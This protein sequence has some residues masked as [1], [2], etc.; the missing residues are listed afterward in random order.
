MRTPKHAPAALLLLL[1]WP[2]AFAQ[3]GAARPANTGRLSLVVDEAA[4]G[5]ALDGAVT[6]R[7]EAQ[8][9]YEH[10]AP[11]T[12][13]IRFLPPSTYQPDMSF[14]KLP[15]DT[16][17]EF[18]RMMS[19][20]LVSGR[21]LTDDNNTTL[22][23]LILTAHQ[24]EWPGAETATVLYSRHEGGRRVVLQDLPVPPSEYEISAR[25]TEGGKERAAVSAREGLP[26]GRS[27]TL[28]VRTPGYWELLTGRLWGRE[29]L[30]IS[31][32]VALVAALAG[33]LKDRIKEA[34]NWLL[35]GLGR[36][37]SG[38]L[39][40][41]RFLRRYLGVVTYNHRYLRLVGLNTAGINR[42]LL[43]EVFV[44]LRITGHGAGRESSAES[45]DGTAEA[46]PFAAA[47]RQ[48][49]K[50]VILGGPGAGK[51]TTLSYAV[52]AFARDEAR[53][54]FG[55]DEKRLPIFIPLRRL[56]D[57][58]RSILEDLLDGET[59]LLQPELLKEHPAGY[60][61]RKLKRGE[62]AVLLDGLDEVVD[63]ATHRRV[64]AKISDM[65]AAY[66]DNRYVVTCRT[67][68][69]HAL[70]SGDFAVL[71]TQDFN[72]EEIQRFVH[73]WHKAVVTQR[74]RARLQLE[75][76]DANRFEA[77]WA[78]HNEET[79]KPAV[80]MRTRSLLAAVD[81]SS[82]ILA[83]AV[84]PMLLSLI[85]LVHYVRR[86]LPK[87]RP[88]LYAQ[89]IELLID[90]WDRSRD[91]AWHV[92][93]R[94][95]PQQKEAVL[96]EIAFEFQ[97]KGVGEDARE[98]LEALVA[99]ISRRLGIGTPAQELLAEIE[100][101]SGLLIERSI[102][103]FG[104]SHLTLQEYL[105]AKHIQLNYSLRG[106][107]LS[108]LGRQ[109]WREVTLLYAG[110]LDDA[111]DLV[112]R[113]S[114]EPT[115]A[116][117]FLAGHCI[118]DAQH[119]SD[120]VSQQVLSELLD[121]LKNDPKLGGAIESLAAA[122]AD[123]TAASA[124]TAGQRLS[125]TLIHAVQHEPNPLKLAAV[126]IL[127]RARVTR[128]LP[129]L[130]PLL[131][132][133]DPELQK[134]AS[135]ALASFA[136]V[137]LAEIERAFVAPATL[138][139]HPGYPHTSAPVGLKATAIH[140][141]IGSRYRDEEAVVRALLACVDVLSEMNTSASAKLLIKLYGCPCEAVR[142][143]VSL[144][145]SRMLKSPFI[146]AD[147]R[148]VELG[149]LPEAVAA[150]QPDG[151]GWKQ[152]ALA[153]VSGFARLDTRIRKDLY[154]MLSAQSEYLMTYSGIDTFSG[155]ARH[156]RGVSFKLLYP[157]VLQH[158]RHHFE[159][160]G[161]RS[162]KYRGA[163]RSENYPT[164][165]FSALGFDEADGKKLS[166][167]TS[168][169][170]ITSPGAL[171]YT[172]RNPGAAA[173]EGGE[174]RWRWLLVSASQFVIYAFY[175]FHWM[176]VLPLLVGPFSGIS[177]ATLLEL[178]RPTL[179]FVLF[180]LAL[181]ALAFRRL[182]HQLTSV[183]I[184]SLLIIP[185]WHFLK[186]LPHLTGPQ[187][188]V[189]VF[190]FHLLFA[191]CNMFGVVLFGHLFDTLILAADMVYSPRVT[192]S[193]GVLLIS[194]LASLCYLNFRVLAQDPIYQLLLLHPEGRR[195]M[196]VAQESK[197]ARGPK[198]SAPPAAV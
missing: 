103:V 120:E 188:W 69:W 117:L 164:E 38:K 122:A 179:P 130:T 192:I 139:R 135:E 8:D 51:T 187:L 12:L 58:A 77:V 36:F 46:V 16:P 78:Q 170:Q 63:E 49:Q 74:E 104:F 96:R 144:A 1:L 183:D 25:V 72:R 114:A 182:R 34:A 140:E 133:D 162:G 157:A 15:P 197:D 109:E 151:A 28:N 115:T 166:F 191:C 14:H 53:Q 125:A 143:A 86:I 185:H 56:T 76:P 171:E 134:A 61:E 41:R 54:K 167:L 13:E 60:F 176:L 128:A 26:A 32:I 50:I 21:W 152:E 18:G 19:A 156:L 6:L 59:Q 129:A 148:G 33:V 181:F 17:V 85:C 105:V 110:L 136:N 84:N 107:L 47:L 163:H 7:V 118:G 3:N 131:A 87:G 150:L 142:G 9:K 124:Q 64:A 198:P 88:V 35:D 82:R 172:L 108:N 75:H 92:D 97:K 39:A 141:E 126:S 2:A 65:V 165:Y 116:R 113:L 146:E 153:P 189:K 71:Q 10:P 137:A 40:E 91:I 48:Y 190:V 161:N 147:L 62:C 80:E 138:R 24:V 94:I 169:T 42:P 44:S 11:L 89:C 184:A 180:D 168:Q 175:I 101:R 66:P 4:L 123:Y 67:A 174:G 99:G 27:Y 112:R 79:V 173:P 55:L 31:I 193:F 155:V 195:L 106:L 95:M 30:L 145:L 127:A 73:G 57:S 119:C 154:S 102:G 68:G 45:R 186:I 29:S 194:V 196:G 20:P 23:N 121:L 98:S 100:Q 93:E 90:A 83:I 70:L 177:G 132:S 111:T 159:S 37:G 22:V 5:V 158:I 160:F 149:H 43:E 81:A 52:L 178:L